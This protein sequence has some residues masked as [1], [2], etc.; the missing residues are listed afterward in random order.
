M[1]DDTTA[2][3]VGVADSF[4]EAFE[5][6]GGTIAGRQGNDYTK[7]QDFTSHADRGR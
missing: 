1:V 6:L 5:A 3:G 7:N 2:F 4:S